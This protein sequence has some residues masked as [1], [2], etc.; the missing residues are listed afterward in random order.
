MDEFRMKISKNG[1]S[2]DKSAEYND[3]YT[4]SFLFGVVP[5]LFY[6]DFHGKVHTKDIFVIKIKLFFS[7]SFFCNKN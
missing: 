5:F 3:I 6:V 4:F 2:E 7:S 1:D